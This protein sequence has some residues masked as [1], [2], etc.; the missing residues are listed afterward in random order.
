MEDYIVRG[1][2]ADNQIRVFAATTRAL[3]EEARKAH[4]TSP[5]ATAALGRLLTGGVMM[6]SMMKGDK[7]LLTLQ[8][9]CNGPI[10]GLTV[11]ADSQGNV[12]GYAY[13][14]N[15][16]LPPSDKGKLDVGK[17]LDLGVLS[18]IK[19]MGLK[20][21]YM[22]QTQLVSGEIAEDLTYY[23]ATSEQVPSA[24]ALGVLM[25]KDN[26]VKR[27]GGFIIQLMPF[28]EDGLAEKLEEKLKNMEPIT[29]LLEKGMT[30]EDIIDSVLGEF[31]VEIMDTLPAQFYCNCT[32]ERVDKAI[33]SVGAKELNEMI[34]EG[35]PIEVNCH[36]CNKNY[37]FSIEEL[38]EILR[39]SKR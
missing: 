22:G 12:K 9:Q 31:G 27:A 6:G 8:I 2:A 24:V 15:V 20:E 30:P 21:P 38:K 29:A 16:M 7:D 32:K 10:K 3:V 23:F 34:Q 33:V 1:T 25:N 13:N 17:A 28:A 39:K 11:T 37:T 19:D 14:P 18:V 4:N 36:F 26:T 35:K 5:V